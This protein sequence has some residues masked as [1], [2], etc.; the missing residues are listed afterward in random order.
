MTTG[1]T[2][3]GGTAN[4]VAMSVDALNTQTAMAA[5]GELKVM[6]GEITKDGDAR[7]FINAIIVNA[8]SGAIP[9]GVI[10]TAIAGKRKN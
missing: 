8:E 4:V 2:G 1:M 9:T 3:S 5:I 6:K 10:E 7:I